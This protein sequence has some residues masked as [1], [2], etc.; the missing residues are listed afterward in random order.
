[1]RMMDNLEFLNGIPVEREEVGEGE[2][3]RTDSFGA[4]V[5]MEEYEEDN[6][7]RMEQQNEG[8]DMSGIAMLPGTILELEE[9]SGT[10]EDI[11]RD[12]RARQQMMASDDNLLKESKSDLLRSKE[13]TQPISRRLSNGNP[14]E[15]QKV[16]L[17]IQDA[18][19]T[20][21][22]GPTLASVSKR[23]LLDS[24]LSAKPSVDL[25]RDYKGVIE[26]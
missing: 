25:I 18:Y 2:E 3:D 8:Y 6:I 15:L 26:E 20:V 14:G 23:S 12:S 13:N 22:N 5:D 4:D 21:E 10:D 9:E 11:N 16:M 24:E 7:E 19:A 17:E 1:M